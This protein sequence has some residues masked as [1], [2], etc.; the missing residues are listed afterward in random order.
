MIDLDPTYLKA[1]DLDPMY[2]KALSEQTLIISVFLGG[3]SAA[4]LGNFIVSNN[5]KRIMKVLIL[6]LVI[7]SS[8]FLLNIIADFGTIMVLTPG[9][10]YG[11][12]I[13]NEILNDCYSIAGPTILIGIISLISVIGLTGWLKSKKLGIAT[14]IVGVLTLILVFYVT[15]Y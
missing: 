10:P 14:T 13:K 1:I 7:A 3:F 2:L 4:I 11:T 6:G 5:N 12:K 15:R 9:Y 8:S